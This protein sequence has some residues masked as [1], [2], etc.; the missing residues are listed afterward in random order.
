MATLNGGVLGSGDPFEATEDALFG[1]SMVLLQPRR[2]TGYR[3]NVDALLL[4]GFAAGG[5]AVSP[6]AT[7]GRRSGP[8]A[9]V[10]FDLGSGVGPVGL[11]LLRFDASERVVM[12]EI[13]EAA[14]RLAR[15]NLEANRWAERGEVV[16][17]DVLD[18]ARTRPG[19]ADLVVCNPPYRTPGRGPA[20]GS[21]ARARVGELG[22]FIAAARQAAG[23]RARV[24]LVYP[25]PDV[26]SL[27]ARLADE[28]LHGKRARF[29]HATPD[30]PARIVLVEARAARAGGLVVLPPLV[31][32]EGGTYTPELRALLGSVDQIAR[33]DSSLK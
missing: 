32:R 18:A 19:Q 28:G 20:R 21:E 14:A 24:C 10:A 22:R 3:T 31:E 7:V 26:G 17:G 11:A 6:S 5:G 15:R 2:G 9:R 4:A 27:L 29:V 30:A 13:D 8:R 25:A 12:I 33:D 1:G 23:H 16:H